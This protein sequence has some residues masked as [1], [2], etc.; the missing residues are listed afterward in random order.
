MLA[1]SLENWDGYWEL[2]NSGSREEPFLPATVL[3]KL[4]TAPGFERGERLLQVACQVSIFSLEMMRTLSVTP[5]HMR[6]D[7]P[8]GDASRS[9]PSAYPAQPTP[10]PRTTML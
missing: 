5:P 1:V 7:E 6:G 9:V 8:C 3:R 4:K 10:L 2:G